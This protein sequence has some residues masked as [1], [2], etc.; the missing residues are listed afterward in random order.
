MNLCGRIQVM[1]GVDEAGEMFAISLSPAVRPLRPNYGF[2][3]DGSGNRTGS[4]AAVHDLQQ[5]RRKCPLQPP[6]IAVHPGVGNGSCDKMGAM[7]LT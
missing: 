4:E 7:G 6:F 5:L 1:S 2:R 3:P